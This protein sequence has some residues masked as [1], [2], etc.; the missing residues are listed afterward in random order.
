MNGLPS[1]VKG[2]LQSGKGREALALVRDQALSRPEDLNMLNQQLDVMIAC[3]DAR[4]VLNILS[5]RT[6]VVETP[7]LLR[8]SLDALIRVRDLQAARYII[9][10]RLRSRI[11][12][13]WL[14]ALFEYVAVVFPEH[15]RKTVWQQILDCLRSVEKQQDERSTM[16]WRTLEAALLFALHDY[17]KYITVVDTIVDSGEG[18]GHVSV[19]KRV[20]AALRA[21][22]SGKAPTKKIFVLGLPKTGTSS[23]ASALS[24]L[25]YSTLHFLNIIT[26]EMISECDFP[27]FDA[28]ADAPVCVNFERCHALFRNAYFIWVER[29]IDEW[30]ESI[31]KHFW[32]YY[33]VETFEEARSML[34]DVDRLNWG[35]K[36]VD[37][38]RR[39]FFDY[40]SYEA[41]YDAYVR[42]LG[43]F[44]AANRDMRLLRLNLNSDRSWQRLCGFLDRDVPNLPFPWENRS[45]A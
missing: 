12:L 13:E 19:H 30:Q 24:I 2:L 40:R 18:M 39:L 6:N 5:L 32:R 35:Q 42:R 21:T 34:Q 17:P 11:T 22:H 38:Y 43:D 28:F 41:A 29:P 4:S 45:P 25:D 1:T 44:A 37:T 15:Q 16:D 9:S 33:G 20:A 3:G 23:I 8:R 7:D 31:T 14:S 36:F 27:L 10:E 26:N